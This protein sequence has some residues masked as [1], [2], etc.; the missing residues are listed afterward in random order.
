M[1][2]LTLL[3]CGGNMPSPKR[4]LSSIFINYKGSKILI[5]CGEGTQM[6]M[7]ANNCGFRDIDLILITHL[8]GDHFFGLPGLLSTIGNSERKKTLNIVG[9][10]GIKN[11]IEHIKALTDGLPYKLNVIE[12]PAKTFSFSEN[13][14]NEIEIQTLPLKH[15][16]ECIGYSLYFRRNRTFDVTKAR[17]NNVPQCAWKHLQK[18]NS[19]SINDKTFTSDMVLGKK[20]LGIKLSIITDTR[21][22]DTIPSFIKNSNLFICEGMYGDD[23]DIDKAIKNKHMTFRESATLAKNGTVNKLLLTHFSP[24]LYNPSHFIDNA[25]NIF[26]NTIIGFDNLNLRIPYPK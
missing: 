19:Y 21:P 13:I 24:S 7:R 22:I 16:I 25:K 15:S 23:L 12:N 9:P 20:R 17:Q 5:D 6:S 11:A 10:T 4:Y 14:L 8:H 26:D 3:G 1:I 2:D 18:N